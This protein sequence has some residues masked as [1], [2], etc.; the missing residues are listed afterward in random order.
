M[1]NLALEVGT[2]IVFALLLICEFFLGS[3]V[4]LATDRRLKNEK[5]ARHAAAKILRDIAALWLV[6][7]I[8]TGA[9]TV[10]LSIRFAT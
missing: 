2:F 10:I 4:L 1:S 6:T 7:F 9:V 8:L 5:V 3:W